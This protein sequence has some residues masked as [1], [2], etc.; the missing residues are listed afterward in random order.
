MITD[1]LEQLVLEALDKL[2]QDGLL[3][4]QAPP[5]IEFERPKRREHGDWSTNVALAVAGGKSPPREMAAALVDRLPSSEIVERA[6][7]AGPGFVNFFLA[8]QWLH[9]VVRLACDP[10]SGFGRS[11]IG[12]GRSVNVEYVSANPTGQINVI[13]GRHASV[14]DAIANLLEAV[15]YQ[16]TREYYFNDA[17]RQMDLF[18]WSVAVRYLQSFGRD[19]EM[20]ADGYMGE[21]VIELAREVARDVGDSLVELDQQ[22]LTGR[23]LEIAV[24][25]VLDAIKQTLER[26]G[27]RF[28]IWFSESRLRAGEIDKAIAILREKDFVEDREGAVW[29]K[30][31][32]FG[33]DK[34][35]VVVRSNGEPT[36]FAADL[37]YLLDK[38]SRGYDH[39][40]YLW[41]ADHHGTVPRL[42]GAAEAFG[43]ERD[44][45]EVRLVQIVSLLRGGAPVVGSKRAGAVVPLDELIDEIG[46]DAARYTYLTRSYDAHLEFDI[47]LVKQQAPENPVY[48]V[49]YAHARISSILRKAQEEGFDFDPATDDLTLLGHDN[50][51]ELMRKLAA[52][53]ELVLLAAERRAPHRVAGYLEELAASFSAFYRDC[54]VMSDDA[55]LSR[56]RLALCLATRRTLADGLALLGV[57]AP[58][59]M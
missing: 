2:R 32:L 24:P 34:D 14:G 45:V 47:E 29:F 1:R 59:R 10:D 28:D 35:R 50:E 9:D 3:S 5:T 26:F 38:F 39:L 54:R 4:I 58:E 27:T 33:D 46:V 37:G 11:S 40:I 44:R 7:V 36:Y 49:Q 15:G 23:M 55:E 43:Y 48:Y 52:F 42:L 56:A 22:Q 12:A 6:D 57:S 19:V 21:E 53:E 8:P 18:A 17:G 41:G 16:V 31:T 30:S 25:R 51:V 13:T 20:P